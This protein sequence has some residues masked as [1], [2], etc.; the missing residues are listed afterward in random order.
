MEFNIRFFF[1]F[2]SAGVIWSCTRVAGH[3]TIYTKR[4]RQYSR[5]CSFLTGWHRVIS[6]ENGKELRS[7]DRGMKCTRSNGQRGKVGMVR[8][9]GKSL[10][11]GIS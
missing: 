8:R 1:F 6:K 5:K 11:V 9:L 2:P 7:V 10:E 3:L 4:L